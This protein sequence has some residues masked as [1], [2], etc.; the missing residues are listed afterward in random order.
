MGFEI[1]EQLSPLS[2]YSYGLDVSIMFLFE[3]YRTDIITGTTFIRYIE[4]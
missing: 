4:K 3:T 1:S 2:F